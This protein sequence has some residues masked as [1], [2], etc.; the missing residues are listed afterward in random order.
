MNIRKRFIAYIMCYVLALSMIPAPVSGADGDG[1]GTETCEHNYQFTEFQ[2]GYYTG[3]EPNRQW[4]KVDKDEWKWPS[5]TDDSN[6]KCIGLFTCDKCKEEVPGHVKT[7]EAEIDITPTSITCGT[8]EKTYTATLQVGDEAEP[9]RDI[10]TVEVPDAGHNYEFTGF[11]WGYY[12]GEDPNRQW[13]KVDKDE[14]AWPDGTVDSDIKCIGLFT[15]DKCEETDAGH[16]KTEEAEIDITPT[17]ITCG[18]E[19]KTYTATLQVGDEAE[20]RRDI[21]TV[22]VPDAGHNYAF[23]GFQ[24]GYYTGE[25]PNRQWNVVDKDE[26]KWPSGTDD[27]DIKCIG[28]FTCDKCKEEV[29]GH[30]KTEEAEIDIT[31][32]S[33]GCVPDETKTYTATLQ[34]AGEE[35]PRR[36]T[37]TVT[38]QFTGHTYQFTRFQWGYYTGEGEARQWNVVDKEGWKWPSGTDDSDIKCIG[39]F[40]CDKCKEEVPG[41]VKTEEAKVTITPPSVTCVSGEKTYSA[42]IQ[43]EGEPKP[44]P[45]IKKVTVP[46]VGHNYAFKGFQWGYYTGEGEARQ[47]N[48][49]DKEGWK[50]PSG[51]DDSDIKCIGLFTCDKC[52]EEVPGHVKTEEAKVTITPP[53]VTCVSGEKTYTAEIQ[54]E[55]EPKPSPDI[56]KVEVPGAGHNYEFTELQWGYYTEEGEARQWNMVDK[57]KVLPVETD[58]SKIKCRASFTCNKCDEQTTDHI[59][60]LQD[61]DVIIEE[62]ITEASTCM[63]Q[64]TKTYVASVIFEEQEYKDTEGIKQ[65]LPLSG[66]NTQKMSEARPATCIADGTIEY[67]YCKTCKKHFSDKNGT[68]ELSNGSWIIKAKDHQISDH[69]QP[70]TNSENGS[71]IRSCDVCGLIQEKFPIPKK[72]MKIEIGEELSAQFDD[73]MDSSKCTF[74]LKNKKD[75]KY[76]KLNKNTGKI[77]VQE[78]YYAKISKKPIVVNV[79][80]GAGTYPVKVTPQIPAPKVKAKDIVAKKE[81]DYYRFTFKYKIKKADK[82]KVRCNLKGIKKEVFDRYLSDPICTSDSYIYLKVGKQKKITF[83]ITAYYGKNVSNTAKIQVPIKK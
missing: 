72:K 67:Y 37:K 9:H 75:K 56:K 3:E 63:K 62:E 81:G 28:L 73:A 66:H 83:T 74:V 41:H 42:E 59:V 27:S 45:D 6:I 70:S 54:V 24:W 13:S 48:K 14:W 78:K 61:D 19:E 17:S 82:V 60:T 77:S 18:T 25:D 43:V 11:Q 49:V 16:V 40:T 50:W 8:E 22:E 29:P 5:G 1:A 35:K 21:K 2:W 68:H 39:L 32:T 10:K 38:V 51:T 47:W 71:L 65:L 69:L 64:G 53:S 23:T 30:V 7:E 33:E 58:G 55:G 46:G 20:P 52:K 36:E 80:T 44:S 31:P 79:S 57:D 15:C 26:W 12:T 76:F 4:N 34:V